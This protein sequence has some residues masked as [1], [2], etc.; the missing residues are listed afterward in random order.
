MRSPGVGSTGYMGNVNLGTSDGRWISCSVE[1]V[2]S[3]R[4]LC[5]WKGNCRSR[6]M[7]YASNGRSRRRR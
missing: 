3:S 2:A 4:P 1:I 6:S 5:G 7:Q